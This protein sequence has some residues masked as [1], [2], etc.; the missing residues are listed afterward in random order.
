[1]SNKGYVGPSPGAPMM[2]PNRVP[3]PCAPPP[4]DQLLKNIQAGIYEAQSR[5]GNAIA[6]ARDFADYALGAQPE[7]GATACG[8]SLAP[9]GIAA[10]LQDSVGVLHTLISQL[11]EQLSRLDR[12]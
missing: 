4:A 2:Q 9:Y 12:L 10:N 11:N 3:M 1:M 6:K 5:V 8:V 7:E